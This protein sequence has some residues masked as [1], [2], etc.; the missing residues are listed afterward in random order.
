VTYEDYLKEAKEKKRLLYRAPLPMKKQR[1]SQYRYQ[2]NG[3][4][5]VYSREE[6]ERYELTNAT[7]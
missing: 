1:V 2:R 5:K 4:V 7:N 6:I 3:E